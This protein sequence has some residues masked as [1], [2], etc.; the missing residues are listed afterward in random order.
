[1]PRDESTSITDSSCSKPV[2]FISNQ[3]LA[4]PHSLSA[5]ELQPVGLAPNSMPSESEDSVKS[6]IPPA[7]FDSDVSSIQLSSKMPSKE[8]VSESQTTDD[9]LQNSSQANLNS[10]VDPI[11]LESSLN[12]GF[13]GP[14]VAAYNVHRTLCSFNLSATRLMQ[15]DDD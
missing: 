5:I 15:V 4:Q 1:M 7:A 2:A 10:C 3:N 6:E 14:S 8:A 11:E 13:S 9:P 12:R